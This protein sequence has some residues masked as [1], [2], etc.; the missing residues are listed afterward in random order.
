MI[1]V[2]E[3]RC[4]D[5]GTEDSVREEIYENL[6]F[7]G[8]FFTILCLHPK[9]SGPT[10]LTFLISLEVCPHLFWLHFVHF[11]LQI[12]FSSPSLFRVCD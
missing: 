10:L 9:L 2:E 7:F 11:S 12:K 5:V 1:F 8:I 4:R 3:R 6:T